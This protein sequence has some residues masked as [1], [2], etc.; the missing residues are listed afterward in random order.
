MQN[1][2]FY[3]QYVYLYSVQ[4]YLW[5]KDKIMEKKVLTKL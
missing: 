1:T 5:R 2:Y 3:T 4:K